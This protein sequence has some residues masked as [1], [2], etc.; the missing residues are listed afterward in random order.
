MSSI[1]AALNTVP[2]VRRTM[3]RRNSNS[4]IRNATQAQS[5]APEERIITT[6]TPKSTKSS[7]GFTIVSSGPGVSSTQTENVDTANG[8]IAITS[9]PEEERAAHDAYIA[10]LNRSTQNRTVDPRYV[11]AAN[12]IYYNGTSNVY[13][14]N[15]RPGTYV[16]RNPEKYVRTPDGR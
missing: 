14:Q 5:L 15:P 13:W 3:A 8:N 11:K 9:L 6:N 16:M 12:D 10:S 7:G 2:V 1:D 4:D